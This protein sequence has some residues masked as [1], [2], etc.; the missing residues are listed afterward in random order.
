[1][2]TVLAPIDFSPISK[3]VVAEAVA[4]A[5]AMGARLVL[6]HV[7]APSVVRKAEAADASVEGSYVLRAEKYVL[8]ELLKWQQRLRDDGITAHTVH[9]IGAAGPLILEQ[10]ER[11]DADCIVMGSHGHGAL[12]DLLAGSTT[13][14][15]LKSARCPVV[16]VPVGATIGD[17]QRV[18]RRRRI[19]DAQPVAASPKKSR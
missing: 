11:L 13:T 10:A 6:F 16:I 4:L 18:F 2:K 9:R 17:K 19:S 7:V 12:Y 5:Q 3:L 1:M 15:V 8:G 14:R